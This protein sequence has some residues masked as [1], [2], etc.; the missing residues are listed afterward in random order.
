[1]IKVKSQ[2][3]AVDRATMLTKEVERIGNVLESS[4]QMLAAIS[5]QVN[6]LNLE[7]RE[8][9]NEIKD[10][11]LTN[12]ADVSE[13][14]ILRTKFKDW[15]EREAS[16]TRD[17]GVMKAEIEMAKQ[18]AT[19]TPKG[20]KIEKPKKTEKEEKK[21][22]PGAEENILKALDAGANSKTALKRET[23]LEEKQLLD[24][25]AKLISDKKVV[26]KKAGKRIKYLMPDQVLEEKVDD[27]IESKKE[28]IKDKI[29]PK[30]DNI[31]PKKEVKKEKAEEK[32]KPAKSLVK[33]KKKEKPTEP[34]PK[35]EKRGKPEKEEEIKKPEPKEEVKD[36]SPGKPKGV[37]KKEDVIKKKLKKEEPVVEEKVPDDK[38]KVEVKKE[39]EK[40]PSDIEII[41]PTSTKKL[42]ELTEEEKRILDVITEDGL[43][44][45]GIQSKVGKDI[46]YT[47]VLRALRILID[48][49][50]VGIVTKGRLTLY[51]KIK[52]EEMGKSK[53]EENKMEVK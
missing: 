23:G 34:I 24:L 32:K 53:K 5:A 26:E 11:L 9:F 33:E 37:P 47:T 42:E 46:T 2:E 31:I 12:K 27:K 20:E 22:Q 1:M 38:K 18:I 30:K 39:P 48:S 16:F 14:D 3:F 13:I 50:Y 43:S 8:E 45:S 15:E 7:I 41:A 40:E 52:V 36:K 49:G 28:P 25:I 35:K 29:P 44:R 6:A 17:L 4:G 19:K 10:N 21:I 51:Q